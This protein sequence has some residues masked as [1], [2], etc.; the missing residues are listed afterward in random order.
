[1][2]RIPCQPF[3]LASAD[4]NTETPIAVEEEAFEPLPE[5]VADR[6]NAD[7]VVAFTDSTVQLTVGEAVSATIQGSKFTFAGFSTV[8]QDPTFNFTLEPTKRYRVTVVAASDWGVLTSGDN[9]VDPDA[10][11]GAEFTQGTGLQLV[12]YD[13]TNTG[14]F[15]IQDSARF[16]MLATEFEIDIVEIPYVEPVPPLAFIPQA[17]LTTA[18]AQAAE[19]FEFTDAPRLNT[20]IKGYA[21][22]PIALT[23]LQQEIQY[24]NAVA[25]TQTGDPNTP[26]TLLY[27]AVSARDFFDQLAV[28]QYE[29]LKSGSVPQSEI[30]RL[31]DEWSQYSAEMEALPEANRVGI[32]QWY[33]ARN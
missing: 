10:V 16:T 26:G 3:L 23:L 19:S 29:N 20:E 32:D 17:D 2:A 22:A 5:S 14:V 18:N 21:G 1:M 13:G 9:Q 8:G 30:N 4:P 12:K 25:Q 33:T 6:L 31:L 28:A 24:W 11:T 7:E 27:R 15:E